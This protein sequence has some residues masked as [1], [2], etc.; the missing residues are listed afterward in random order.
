MYIC[1]LKL[2]A[3]PGEGPEKVSVVRT[4]VNI[5]PYKIYTST[6][7]SPNDMKRVASTRDAPSPLTTS[8]NRQRVL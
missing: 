1:M 2:V 3:F 5:L 8:T 6:M 7:F 4:S